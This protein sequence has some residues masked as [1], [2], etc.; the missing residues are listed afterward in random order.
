MLALAL[1]DV[2]LIN[3]WTQ[4]IGRYGASN[5]GLLEVIFECNLKL[6]GQQSAKK[7]LFVLRDF[8]DV[9][10][11]YSNFMNQIS[12]DID[13]I[14]GKIYKPDKYKDKRAQDFFDIEFCMLP[15]KV[16]QED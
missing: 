12:V 10:N 9:G 14:W 13:T 15:H 7:L 3:M 2:L 6:F 16:F 4:D 5:Y 1:S 8:N 11:N